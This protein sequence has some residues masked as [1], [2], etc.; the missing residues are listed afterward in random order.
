MKKNIIYFILIFSFKIIAQAPG[1]LYNQPISITNPNLQNAVNYQMQLTINTQSLISSGQMSPSGNDIRFTGTCTGNIFYNY[2]IQ[3]G[4][5]TPTT[6]IWVKIPLIA[7]NTTTTI[8]MSYGNPAAIAQ[9]T[10]Q[11]TF[12]GPNSA[13]DSVSGGTSGGNLVCQRGFRFQPT[14]NLLVTHFGKNEPTGST[15]YV[16]LFNYG[17]QAIISLTQVAGPSASYTYGPISSPIWLNP[18]TQYVLQI[19]GLAND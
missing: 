5:N 14:Q 16:T 15:R 17:N 4:I 6:I 8:F 10:I 9:S 11:G 1:W 7:A 18:A 3:S 13:T 19:Y 2:W 12:R